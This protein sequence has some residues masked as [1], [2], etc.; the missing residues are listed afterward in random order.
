MVCWS[1][2]SLALTRSMCERH[3]LMST[4]VCN[5]LTSHFWMFLEPLSA[6]FLPEF[7]TLIM[8]PSPSMF[9]TVWK[10]SVAFL[11]WGI[12][13]QACAQDDLGGICDLISCRELV[14]CVGLAIFPVQTM[15]ELFTTCL[16]STF[17]LAPNRLAHIRNNINKQVMLK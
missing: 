8:C 7:L 17:K 12:F 16:S 5:Q 9:R 1:S 13:T 6:C 3:A 11:S 10:A 15:V 4:F 14:F 2:L